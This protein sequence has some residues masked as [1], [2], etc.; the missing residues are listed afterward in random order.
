M[1]HVTVTTEPLALD[2]FDYAFQEDPYP[3]LR[4]APRRRAA[5][6]QPGPRP[7]G[8]HPARRHRRGVPHR[9]HHSNSWGVAIE[10]SAW[11]PDAHKAMSILGMDPPRQNRLR[12]L[13]SRGFTPRRVHDRSPDPVAD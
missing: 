5:A 4:P 10:Q 3:V 1:W 2:P 9:G 13:V 12:S 7:V 6:P 8:T 11:G